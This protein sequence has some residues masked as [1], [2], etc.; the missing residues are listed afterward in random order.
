[1]SYSQVPCDYSEVPF[2]TS[3][4][5]IF[6]YFNI[7]LKTKEFPKDLSA[8]NAKSIELV[9]EIIRKVLNRDEQFTL[10]V[11]KTTQTRYAKDS[12]LVLVPPIEVDNVILFLNLSF[13]DV[14][15]YLRLD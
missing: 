11:R 10:T 1:V 13:S 14:N 5:L 12:S 9:K 15:F 7:G 2:V 8:Q 3:K 4:E 6:Y